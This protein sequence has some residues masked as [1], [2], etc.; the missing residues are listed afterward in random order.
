MLTYRHQRQSASGH[1]VK[2]TTRD[3]GSWVVTT[4]T[5]VQVKGTFPPSPRRFDPL[6]C[7][8][9][10]PPF[11][12]PDSSVVVQPTASTGM[13]HLPKISFP[14]FNGENPCLWQSCCIDYFE[15]YSVAESFW[16]H[17][18]KQHLDPSDWTNFCRL[19]HDCFGRDQKEL[20]IRQLFHVCQ[21]SSVS[22]YIT[23]FTELVDQLAAYSCHTDPMYS[24]MRFVDALCADISSPSCWFC[25]HSISILLVQLHCCRKRRDLRRP[26]ACH[27]LEIGLWPSSRHPLA[28]HCSFP[29]H[30]AQRS[31]R[32]RRL[33]L[34]RP[35]TL[36]WQLL[37]LTIALWGCATNAMPNGVRTISVLL[38]SSTPSKH[39]GNQLIS[40]TFKRL[41]F[42]MLRPLSNCFW[43]SPRLLSP[44]FLLHVQFSC[45]TPFVMSQSRFL[46]IPAVPHLSLTLTW[47]VAFLQSSLFPYLLLCKLLVVGCFIVHS[48]C[49]RF[50][51]PLI[52]ARFGLI[53]ECS[54]WQRLMW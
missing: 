49:I 43:Q 35:L 23:Q 31:P 3:V 42:L 45:S 39:Y 54:H 10:K 19:L 51:G 5:H 53:L 46:S 13:G 52:S 34:P 28:E 25:V 16:I 47:S 14:S 8:P 41:K 17:V 21:T 22:A 12:P 27:T 40:K 44:G 2:S 30:K 32:R 33:L 26:R 11:R 29:R 48:C 36:R 38:K 18:P 9:P 24:T 7:L 20:L 6:V 4:W 37:C 50:A 15:M 1:H